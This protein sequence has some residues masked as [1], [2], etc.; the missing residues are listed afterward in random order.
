MYSEINSVLFL[1]HVIL[2]EVLIQI[3]SSMLT[4]HQISGEIPKHTL[5]IEEKIEALDYSQ[6]HLSERCRKLSLKLWL[7][8]QISDL[9]KNEAKIRQKYA[10][11]RGTN[12][13]ARFG[14]YQ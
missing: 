5:S 12:E 14:E 6:S 3:T 1:I 2:H 8:R 7:E 13:R 10:E 11:F 4:K 9:L